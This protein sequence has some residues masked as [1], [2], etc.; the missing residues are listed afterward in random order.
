MKESLG[1]KTLMYP[2]PVL[3]VGTFDG[4]GRPNVMTA[5]W[6]GLCCSQPPCA[7]VSLRKATYT[8]GNVLERRAYTIN[9]PSEKHVEEVDYFGLVTGRDTDKFAAT[10]LIF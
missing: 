6:G 5:S 8:Y 2:A 3:V 10:K 7:A 1:A 9:I 4:G